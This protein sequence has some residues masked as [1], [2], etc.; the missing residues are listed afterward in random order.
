MYI[1]D[2]NFNTYKGFVSEGSVAS[3]N[4]DESFGGDNVTYPTSD[5]SI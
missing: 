3:A 4:F 1:P 5:C 2:M